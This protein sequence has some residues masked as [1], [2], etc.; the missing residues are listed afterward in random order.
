MATNKLVSFPK[1][2]LSFQVLVPMIFRG[3]ERKAPLPVG[4]AGG[5]KR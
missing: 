2:V 4:G 5:G 1:G 3:N